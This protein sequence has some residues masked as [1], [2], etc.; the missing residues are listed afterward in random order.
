M[1]HVLHSSGGGHS[2]G[3]GGECPHSKKNDDINDI[4]DDVEKEDKNDH[5]DHDD[6][7]DHGHSHDEHD[8]QHGGNSKCNKNDKKV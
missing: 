5:E 7:D 1:G 6:H 3:L 2:H 8:H 4:L